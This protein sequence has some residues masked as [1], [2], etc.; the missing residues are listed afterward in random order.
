MEII[1]CFYNNYK[2]GKN[3]V[4]LANHLKNLNIRSII[5]PKISQPLLAKICKELIRI[6]LFFNINARNFFLQQIDLIWRIKKRAKQIEDISVSNFIDLIYL[7]NQPSSN[8]EGYFA[9]G[10]LNIP[11][12]QHSRSNILLSKYEIEIINKFAHS[13]ICN[14]KGV[15]KTLITQ[16]INPLKLKVVYNGFNFSKLPR[17]ALF[18]KSKL[19]DQLIIG[20]VSSLIKRKSINHII[21]A[22]NIIRNSFNIN[23]HLIIVGDGVEYENL[24]KY[25]QKIGIFDYVTFAK[26]SKNPLS[27]IQLMD[28][29]VLSSKNEG[30]GRVIVEAMQCKKP[31][32]S[33]R[34]AGP[35]EIILHKKTGYLYTYGNINEMA[36]F[37]AK[38]ASDKRK[39]ILMGSAGFKRV[40]NLFDIDNYVIGVTKILERA[41]S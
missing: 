6:F 9:G 36:S 24:R 21:D 37:I 23:A 39:R 15:K 33:S 16:G 17:K 19:K 12:V 30:F 35:S 18:N 5:L 8:L 27:W 14:S 32:V 29:F 11:I 34:S 10:A 40:K 41:I 13:I 20:T 7:N 2:Q 1:C 3:G 22:L 25:S 28:I 4:S 26:F 31:V 38:L